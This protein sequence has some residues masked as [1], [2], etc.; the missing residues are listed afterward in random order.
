M[1]GVRRGNCA[2]HRSEG[3]IKVNS[4]TIGFSATKQKDYSMLIWFIMQPG[5]DSVQSQ[6]KSKV[7]TYLSVDF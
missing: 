5:N 1:P 6:K 3:V 7:L 4:F 2:K